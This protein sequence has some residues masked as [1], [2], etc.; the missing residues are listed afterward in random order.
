MQMFTRSFGSSR[1]LVL[2][3]TGFGVLLSLPHMAS[4]QE[5]L[6]VAALSDAA[7]SSTADFD[8]PDPQGGANG[9]VNRNKPATAPGAVGP[10]AAPGY[11]FPSTKDMTRYWL[12]NT[13][14]PKAFAAAAFSASWST[15]VT[16]TPEEWDGFR[17]WSQRFGVNMLDGGINTSS[18]VLLSGALHQD[19]RYLRCDCTG[20]KARL[21]HA[22]KM[23]YSSRN[24]NGDLIFAPVKLATPFAGPFITRNYIYPDRFNNGDAALGGT[25]N[26]AGNFA[27]NVI[28]EFIFRPRY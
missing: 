3:F 23:I 28:R 13:I 5:F 24:H 6:D 25:F 15:W 16:N 17:G 21:S 27:W 2:F 9:N 20:S 26:I 10:T 19:P 18:L 1:W 4:A 14:G 11:V 22:F 12:Y 8:P 7:G